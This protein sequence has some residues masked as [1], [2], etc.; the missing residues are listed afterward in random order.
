M[1]CKA[2]FLL[3]ILIFLDLCH[4]R[5]FSCWYTGVGG[6]CVGVWASH[7]YCVLMEEYLQKMVGKLG[8]P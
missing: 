7:K 1:T 3:H 4:K 2:G 8:K 6:K 5:Y